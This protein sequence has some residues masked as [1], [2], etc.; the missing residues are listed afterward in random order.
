MNHNDPVNHHTPAVYTGQ[1][2]PGGPAAVREL[3]QLSVLKISVGAMDNSTYVLTC[4]ATGQQ[5]LIDAA[6]QPQR[7]LALLDPARVEAIVTTHSHHDHWQQALAA[8]RA[9]CPQAHTYAGAADTPEI[10]VPTD[11]PLHNGDR[12]RVG[13]LELEVV[14]LRGHT[15]GGIALLYTDSRLPSGPAADATPVAGRPDTD[16]SVTGST[17]TTTGHNTGVIGMD[18]PLPTH[19]LWTGDSLFPGGPGKTNSPADFTQLMDDMQSRIFARLPD[20][21]WVYPG[22]GNDT[23]L[24][25][26]RPHLAAWRARGW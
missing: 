4:T 21:T 20:S 9:A 1:V 11:V 14:G 7:L 17:T 13:Q 12:V 10:G 15:P 22:H 6:A 23:T 18:A 26:E 5:M 3:G 24:G 19:H 8:V 2:R 25:A 16:T